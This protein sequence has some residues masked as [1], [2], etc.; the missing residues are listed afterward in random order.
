MPIYEAA[1]CPLHK[2]RESSGLAEIQP[3]NL[4][5]PIKDYQHV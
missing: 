2:G 1:E 5:R 3:S 4:A